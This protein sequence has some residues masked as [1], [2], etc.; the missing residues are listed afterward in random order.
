MARPRKEIDWK[1]FDKLCEIQC[2]LREI[3]SF[4]GV[5]EDTVERAVQREYNVGFK[6]HYEL[7]SAKGK[8]SLRR[9]QFQLAETGNATMLIWLGKQWL[10]QKDR[11]DV[12]SG[13]EPITVKILRGVSTDDL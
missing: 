5:S 2:T 10:D 3:A 12:T 11:S 1:A 9:L 6:E 13:G 4:L 7:K 8:A